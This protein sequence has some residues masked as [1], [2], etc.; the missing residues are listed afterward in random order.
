L[1]EPS[2]TADTNA[3]KFTVTSISKGGGTYAVTIK[4]PCGAK[5]LSVTVK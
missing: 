3:V 4:S 1:R 5:Q 2:K